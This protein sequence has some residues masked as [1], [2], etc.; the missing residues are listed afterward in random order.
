MLGKIKQLDL[1]FENCDSAIIPL[2]EIHGWFMCINKR[3]FTSCNQDEYYESISADWFSITFKDLMNL[4]YTPNF[5]DDTS[6][7]SVFERIQH[8]DIAQVTIVFEDGTDLNVSAP[9]G[10]HEAFYNAHQELRKR[11]YKRSDLPSRYQI[12]I[13]N[14]WTLKK[15]FKYLMYRYS[16]RVFF[17]RF[18]HSTLY[19]D[20]RSLKDR[21]MSR[22]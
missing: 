14:K 4:K 5:K 9:W 17:W 1:V 19:W 22:G 20:L 2:A 7:Y 16:P 3:W 21:I 11:K 6:K 18:K 10:G 13:K 12:E 8:P 15:R